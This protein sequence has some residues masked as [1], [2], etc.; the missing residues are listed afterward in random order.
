M[1]DRGDGTLYMHAAGNEDSKEAASPGGTGAGT[2]AG[3]S[4]GAV[5]TDGKRSEEEEVD[6]MDSSR[7]EGGQE[8]DRERVSDSE[9]EGVPRQARSV[10]DLRREASA[11]MVDA[12]GD[13]LV[14]EP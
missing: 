8:I 4:A 9:G 6:P 10:D 14:A 5:E 3:G 2:G 11:W 7:V 12:F 1:E 13:W